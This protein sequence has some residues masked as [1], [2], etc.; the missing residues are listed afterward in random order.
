MTDQFPVS[1]QDILVVDDTPGNLR[2]LSDILHHHAYP[3]RTASSGRGALLE[4]DRALPDL[5]LLDVQMPEMDGYQVCETLKAGAHTRDIPVIFI[6]GQHE[7]DAKLKAF[8]A[9]GLDYITKPFQAVEVLAR[10]KTHLAHHRQEQTRALR[11]RL[12]EEAIRFRSQQLVEANDE[13]ALLNQT[14]NE[15]LTLV[16]HQVR[17]P[18][19]GLLGAADLAF[20]EV[21]SGALATE[22]QQMFEISR[23]RLL[24]LLDDTLLLARLRLNQPA[25]DTSSVALDEVLAT[26]Q[27]ATINLGEPWHLQLP[28]LPAGLGTVRG[29]A[30]LLAKALLCLVEICF[31]CQRPETPAT[32]GESVRWSA[33]AW[34]DSV[35]LT[36][37]S[38]HHTIP[39]GDLPRFFEVLSA[40]QPFPGGDLGLAPALAGQILKFIGGGVE[41]TNRTPTGLQFQIWLPRPTPVPSS[42]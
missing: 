2:V 33:D 19:N 40:S 12:L 17:T 21:P 29:Q 30:A 9:G 13:L 20:R 18:L 6:S 8:T 5:V 7:T 3:V 24:E 1:C 26:V 34:P 32:G 14:K 10:V 25:G 31:K 37:T 15:F 27:W 41:A 16:A 4:I 22:L 39:S 38:N 11:S 36:L 35:V 23:T 28:P 42:P